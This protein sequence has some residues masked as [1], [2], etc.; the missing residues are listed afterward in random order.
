MHSAVF[1]TATCPSVRLSQPVLCL[2]LAEQKQ[3]REMYTNP[4]WHKSYAVA[5]RVGVPKGFSPEDG[6][7]A[8][9]L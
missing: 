6:L 3:D 9:L 5:V 2:V 1:A 7:Y 8:S 4:S